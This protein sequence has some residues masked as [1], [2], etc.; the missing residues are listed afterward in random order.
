MPE[1]EEERRK[2][3]EKQAKEVKEQKKEDRGSSSV[4][5]RKTKGWI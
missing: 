2:R 3:L 5:K 4:P 1:T